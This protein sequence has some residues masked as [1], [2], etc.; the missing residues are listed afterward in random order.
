[1]PLSER[2]F[3]M[4]TLVN[5]E[6]LSL[7]NLIRGILTRTSILLMKLISSEADLDFNLMKKTYGNLV[8]SWTITRMYFLCYI[9]SML[10][11]PQRSICISSNGSEIG[12]SMTIRRPFLDGFP[13]SHA[14]LIWLFSKLRSGRPRTISLEIR[15]LYIGSLEDQASN[16]I[17]N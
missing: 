13:H 4:M 11:G 17:T 6:P 10:E 2:K 9:L 3:S 8:W 5:F 12:F 14:T 1:M 7:R 16:S 15:S